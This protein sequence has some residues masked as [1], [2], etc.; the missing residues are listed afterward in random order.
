MFKGVDVNGAHE[1]GW[2]P[3]HVAAVNGKREVS[4]IMGFFKFFQNENKHRLALKSSTE[5]RRNDK[6][7]KIV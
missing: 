1:L 4:K 2:A 3:L 5:N 7:L 6:K